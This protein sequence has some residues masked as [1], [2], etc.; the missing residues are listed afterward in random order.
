M[1]EVNNSRF[2]LTIQ[3]GM[4][5][6][7]YILGDAGSGVVST[8]IVAVETT[9]AGTVAITVK[10]RPRGTAAAF[11]PIEYLALCVAGTA[12]AG[13]TYS[14]AA[15]AGG[16][17]L[18]HIPSSGMDIALDVVFTAGVHVIYVGKVVGASA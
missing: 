1:A 13:G 11:V 9:S 15:L 12:A 17:D 18:I 14:G 3:T 2:P 10:A 5:T 6:N 8:T 16:G 7:T 4:G